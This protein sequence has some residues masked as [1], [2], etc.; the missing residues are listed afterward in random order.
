[1]FREI[2]R[3]HHTTYFYL[4][5]N[6]KKAELNHVETVILQYHTNLGIKNENTCKE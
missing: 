4:N 6:T 1:M 5:F 3:I 2:V